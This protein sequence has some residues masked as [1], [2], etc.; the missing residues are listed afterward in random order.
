MISIYQTVR[1]A[2]IEAE[3]FSRW[4][5]GE[6]IL[7]SIYST[8]RLPVLFF[9]GV[10]CVSVAGKACVCVCEAWLRK[11]VCEER[12]T[13]NLTI[14]CPFS[15]LCKTYESISVQWQKHGGCRKGTHTQR[16]SGCVYFIK[17]RVFL[18]KAYRR[19]GERKGASGEKALWP[20]Y[21]IM[22]YFNVLISLW[23]T[24]SVLKM[25]ERKRKYALLWKYMVKMSLIMSTKKRKTQR[26]MLKTM[27]RWR[28]WNMCN[29]NIQPEQLMPYRRKQLKKAGMCNVSKA[30][31]AKYGFSISIWKPVFYNNESAIRK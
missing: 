14:I 5:W 1:E 23:P 24:L 17:R 2:F 3:A 10:S 20:V 9:N 28:K 7:T 8:M 30:K 16:K 25:S 15:I 12:E 11:G 27:W 4:W 21:G 13:C 22:A 31:S 26:Y 6:T 19:G 18:G 29:S